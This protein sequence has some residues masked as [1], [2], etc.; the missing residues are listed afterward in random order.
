MLRACSVC[1]EDQGPS[2]FIY[3]SIDICQDRIPSAANWENVRT[4]LQRLPIEHPFSTV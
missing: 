2:I 4:D 1:K 3:P